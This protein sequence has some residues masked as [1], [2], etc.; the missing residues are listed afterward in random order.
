MKCVPQ[1]PVSTGNDELFPTDCGRDPKKG[2]GK[3]C[4]P[5]G[6]L[7]KNSELHKKSQNFQAIFYEVSLD[8]FVNLKCV[9]LRLC[10]MK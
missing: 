8:V 7:C 4:F 9:L 5:D 1:K 3:L 10:V 6:Q 2:T